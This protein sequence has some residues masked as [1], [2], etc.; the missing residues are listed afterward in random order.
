MRLP[1]SLL[2]LIAVCAALAAGLVVRAPIVP[3][4]GASS[5]SVAPVAEETDR[6]GEEAASC[7]SCHADVVDRYHTTAHARSMSRFDPATAPETFDDAVVCNEPS[8]LCYEAFVRDGDLYQREFRRNDEGEVVHAVT[9]EADYVIGSG[10]ATRSYLMDENGYVTEMPLTWYVE[11]ERWDMSPGYEASN[12]R[13]G[14]QINLECMTC[15]NAT[16]KRTPFTQNHYTDIPTG[17]SCQRC[18]ARADDHASFQS[19]GGQGADPMAAASEQTREQKLSTCQQCHL[20]GITTFASGEDP[21]TYEAGQVLRTNR[22]VHVPKKQLTDTSWV[23]IDSHPIRLARSAC[24]KESAM[25]CT[26]CHDPHQPADALSD[27]DYNTTCQSCHQQ[28]SQQ[29][30]CARPAA[31][32]PE[33]ATS[34]NCVSCHLQQGGTSDV[35]HVTFT[36]H[37]I[38]ER[39]GP[40]RDPSAGRPSFDTPNPLPLVALRQM[41][42]LAGTPAATDTTAARAAVAYFRFYETMHRH[43]SYVQRTIRTGRAALRDASAPAETRIALARALAEDDSTAAAASVMREAARTY[44]DDA[45]VQYWHGALAEAAGQTDVARQAYRRAIDIQPKMVEAQQGL[46]G[47]LVR[48]GQRQAALDRLETL[49]AIDSVHVPQAWYNLGVLRAQ[50]GDVRSAR[51][52]YRTAT[53]LNPDLVQAHL[54][55][56]RLYFRVELFERAETHFQDARVAAP[57]NAS[58]H[59]SLGLL[60]L[61][62]G[63]AAKARHHLERVLEIDPSNANARSLLRKLE[64]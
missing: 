42:A 3:Q 34:G 40:P 49:V 37:W 62:T 4:A 5:A 7:A 25:T 16:P 43:P 17:I 14:R 31:T 36:D 2:L 15:H 30:L 35:P 46:A 21:T 1:S 18:H 29:T 55:L 33:I 50:T 51:D 12:D 13:F 8:N 32:T 19:S 28:P 59:G 26:T 63:E 61:R 23:G 11:A 57:N 39:P 56:G 24:F 52:A 10:N 22:T 48:T 53:H 41:T 44:P 27:A 20:A 38:R 45:W 9:F 47:V 54:Q 58:V 60:Y 6:S 64:R